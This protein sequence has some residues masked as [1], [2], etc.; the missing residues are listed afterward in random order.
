MVAVRVVED[1]FDLL[2]SGELTHAQID[3]YLSSGSLI[4]VSGTFAPGSARILTAGPGIII[5]DNGP[6][7]TLVISASAPQ[8]NFSWNEVPTG[9]V[10][11]SNRAFNFLYAP[12][13]PSA[14]M[15]FLNGQKQREGAGSDFI[16]SGSTVTFDTTNTPRSGANIDATYQY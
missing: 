7:G 1:H 16:L 13:P 15:L 2:N 9:L 14:F 4:V 8:V 12:N 5:Q 10:D 6:G 11:G 3:N